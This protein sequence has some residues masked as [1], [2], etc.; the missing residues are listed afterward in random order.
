MI[1]GENRKSQILNHVNLSRDNFG[2]FSLF[3]AKRQRTIEEHLRKSL[4]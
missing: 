3:C 2:D 1:S 4:G